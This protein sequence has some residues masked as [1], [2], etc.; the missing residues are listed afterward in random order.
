MSS[1]KNYIGFSLAVCF[2]FLPYLSISIEISDSL[3]DHVVCT[4]SK[5]DHNV[6]L[7]SGHHAGSFLKAN[8]SIK[9]MKRC[10]QQCCQM[11]GCD[12]AF[13]S[14]SACYSVKC[15]NFETCA[16]VANTNK[17]MKTSI[18]FVA[19]PKRKDSGTSSGGDLRKTDKTGEPALSED[20]IA[21][22]TN[23]SPFRND[24]NNLRYN[25]NLNFKKIKRHRRE[26][27]SEYRDIIIALTSGFAAVAVGVLG[28]ITMTRKLVEDDDIYT[29][30][31]D[32]WNDD[33]TTG[34]ATENKKNSSSYGRCSVPNENANIS[35][36]S[37]ISTSK[38]EVTL[39]VPSSSPK[40]NI[41]SNEK[42][43]SSDPS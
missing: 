13:F 20:L 22:V 10:V 27:W 5:I 25:E 9:T 21:E 19:R 42:V 29:A 39:Q 41:I 31:D 7:A 34:S 23:E 37:I 11:K 26:S 33:P 12:V 43:P 14:N 16:P 32:I 28:V 35:K 2:V 4:K 18:S 24:E 17:R 3:G 15:T 6:T 1:I 8:K 36:G 38:V 30:E 40:N